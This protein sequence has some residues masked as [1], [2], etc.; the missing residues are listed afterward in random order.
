M[1]QTLPC[2]DRDILNYEDNRI[3]ADKFLTQQRE[4]LDRN[5]QY[6]DFNK[7]K[8]KHLFRIADENSD[9]TQATD[10]YMYSIRGLR[11]ALRVRF[12]N[13]HTYED[14]TIRSRTAYNMKTEIHKIRE[15]YGD[16]Y[17]YCWAPDGQKITQ[18]VIFDLD[19]FR[20]RMDYYLKD[21]DI[22]CGDGTCMT[23]FDLVKMINDPQGSCV[24]L[25]C[26]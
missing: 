7:V 20:N 16:Y 23:S 5:I 17:L 4:I 22:P 10:M 26:P 21:V 8:D 9:C 13:M 2:N 6:F 12:L 19:K 14:I 25:Y 24:V 15:G 18:W 3:W 1:E 11:I